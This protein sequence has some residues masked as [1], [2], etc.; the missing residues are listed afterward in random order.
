MASKLYF[1]E[2]DTDRVVGA[3]L[4]AANGSAS[5]KQTFTAKHSRTAW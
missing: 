1:V 2:G 5:A 4:F 3:V